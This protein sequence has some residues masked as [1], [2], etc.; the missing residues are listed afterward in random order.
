MIVS[1]IRIAIMSI[2]LKYIYVTI[3]I[4]IV[5]FTPKF[6]LKFTLKFTFKVEYKFIYIRKS[7]LVFPFPL[8]FFRYIYLQTFYIC[9]FI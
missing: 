8:T 4:V 1:V 7:V 6:T 5:Q 9:S 2:L 3:V